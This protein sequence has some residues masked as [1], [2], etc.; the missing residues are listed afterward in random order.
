MMDITN[1]NSAS[2]KTRRATRKASNK[3]PATPGVVKNAPN[4]N[5]P[6][7]LSY[8]TALFH[9]N[10]VYLIGVIRYDHQIKEPIQITGVTRV[11]T[12]PN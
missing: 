12:C 9:H 11:K 5:L 7:P 8:R 1:N 6:S 10:F 2:N 3:Q 4:I